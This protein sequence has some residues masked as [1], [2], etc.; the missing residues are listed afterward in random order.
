MSIWLYCDVLG[1]TV[2]EVGGLVPGLYTIANITQKH[3]LLPALGI[4]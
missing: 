2:G 3:Y 4:P 1:V